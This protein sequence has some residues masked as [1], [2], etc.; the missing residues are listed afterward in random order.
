MKSVKGSIIGLHRSAG[1]RQSWDQIRALVSGTWTKLEGADMTLNAGLPDGIWW[2]GPVKVAQ[3]SSE[4]E[5]TDMPR[6][7]GEMLVDGVKKIIK[8]VF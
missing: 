7:P 5:L 1:H 4:A 3:P 8:P 2:L 6:Q